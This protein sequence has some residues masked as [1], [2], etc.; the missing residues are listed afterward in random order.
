MV[1]ENSRNDL[2]AIVVV[3]FF[4]Y[5]LLRK[6]ELFSLLLKVK[7]MKTNN[8]QIINKDRKFLIKYIAGLYPPGG[9]VAL[10][11][12]DSTNINDDKPYRR[13]KAGGYIALPVSKK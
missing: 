3:G 5:F 6:K 2:P 7:S 1:Y 8:K 9:Y 10:P 12:W 13:T 11:K 4:I